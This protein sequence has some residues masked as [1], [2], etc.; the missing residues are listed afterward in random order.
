MNLVGVESYTQKVVLGVV[1]LLAV[2]LD[3]VKRRVKRAA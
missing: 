3:M 2:M 1:I